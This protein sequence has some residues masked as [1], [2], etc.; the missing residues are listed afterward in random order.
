MRIIFLGVEGVLHPVSAISKFA[1]EV[2][3]QRAVQKFWLFRWAWI[4]AELL[5][6]HPDVGI[7]VHSNWRQL[8]TDEEL[9]S[10]LGPLARRFV[11]S[12]PPG[13]KGWDG[14]CS[15][16]EQNK[17]RNFVILDSV[18][19]AFPLAVRELIACDAEMGL[20]A[21]SVRQQVRAWLRFHGQ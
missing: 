13:S 7:V 9:Q 16:V 11:G 15:V 10:F 19:T 1:L 2:P 20:K 6:G 4:L 18:P 12:V 21:Y 17:L 3:L 14:I 8:A 5:D